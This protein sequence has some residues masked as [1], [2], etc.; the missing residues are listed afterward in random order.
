MSEP[1]RC[2]YPKCAEQTAKRPRKGREAFCEAHA[3]KR[4]TAA[5]IGHCA[6]YVMPG[7]G[8]CQKHDREIAF[9]DAWHRLRHQEAATQAQ[10][11]QEAQRALRIMGNGGSP[12]PSR[13]IRGR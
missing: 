8:W 1:E 6:Q 5:Q 7:S 13:L 10:E 12:D 9:L 4:C 11:A 2:G 3:D